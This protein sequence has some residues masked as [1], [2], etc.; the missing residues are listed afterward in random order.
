MDELWISIA[1]GLLICV[2][3]GVPWLLFVRFMLNK[4]Y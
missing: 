3:I 4:D 1:S 2:S